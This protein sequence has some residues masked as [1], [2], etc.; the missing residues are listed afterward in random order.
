VT[1]EAVV[2]KYSILGELWMKVLNSKQANNRLLHFIPASADNSA[3][4]SLTR[5]RCASSFCSTVEEKKGF[6]KPYFT[7]VGHEPAEK[8]QVFFFAERV[9]A[10]HTASTY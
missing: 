1:Q 6:W 4:T 7:T 10:K 3:Q 8:K 5:D 2:A 9:Y